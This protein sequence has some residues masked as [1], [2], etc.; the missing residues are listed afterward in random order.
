MYKMRI[1][2]LI[3]VVAVV[4]CGGGGG[5]LSLLML[6]VTGTVV[7]EEVPA[8]RIEHSLTQMCTGLSYLTRGEAGSRHLQEN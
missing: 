6:P 4:V 8:L 5:R 7:P 3:F 1:I 2:S